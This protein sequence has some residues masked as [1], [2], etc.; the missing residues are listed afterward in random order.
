ML[1]IRWIGQSG[2][3]LND[4][5][6][7]IC[8]DP[9]LSDAVN[10]LAGRPRTRPIPIEPEDVKS[11]IIICTHNH[12]DHID[13]D[14]IPKMNKEN[15]QF[16]A[17][18][19]CEQVLRELGVKEFI[20]FD[21]GATMVVGDF[22]ISAVFADHTIPAIGVIIEHKGQKLYFTGDTFYNERLES[23]ICDYMFICIN[24]KLGNMTVEEAIRLT[25]KIQPTSAV[26][27]HYDMF[28]SNRENPERFAVPNRFI[29]EF[30]RLYSLEE[31][32]G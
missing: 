27:N 11:N 3:I 20:P 24:G 30:N 18:S 17:P 7:E 4:G 16:L 13:I 10:R 9:Y 21:L 14:A 23:I 1:K 12:L 22:K 5:N 6:T 8:I 15:M 28:E 31:L 19:C 32:R 26:P 25:E 2:Y 29:M